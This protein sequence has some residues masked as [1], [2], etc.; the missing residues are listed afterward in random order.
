VENKQGVPPPIAPKKKLAKK[1]PWFAKLTLAAGIPILLT[2]GYYEPLLTTSFWHL[3]YGG[4]MQYRGLKIHVPWGWTADMSTLRDD[5]PLNPQ[6]VSMQKAPLNLTLES[7][8]SELIVVNV[9]MHDA[10]ATDQQQ[11]EQWRRLQLDTHP[12]SSYSVDTPDDKVEGADCLRARN[13]RSTQDVVWTCLSMPDGWEAS[14]E[15]HEKDV[16]QFLKVVRGLKQ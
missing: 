13:L 16:P 11:L 10:H 14:Y 8:E 15:G 2:V 5:P 9:R 1:I 12:S 3:L 4:S 7:Q 6:G